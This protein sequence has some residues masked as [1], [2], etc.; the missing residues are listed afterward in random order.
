M[1]HSAFYEGS[2]LRAS[3]WLA[4][5][6]SVLSNPGE[7]LLMFISRP[8]QLC[9]CVNTRGS[10]FLR[11][12]C[13]FRNSS[14]LLLFTPEPLLYVLRERKGKRERER[15]KLVY[16]NNPHHL[17]LE[18]VEPSLILSDSWME[19]QMEVCRVKGLAHIDQSYRGV[20]LAE[21]NWGLLL[22]TSAH[23]QGCTALVL[24]LTHYTMTVLLQSTFTASP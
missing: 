22:M 10:Y 6:L 4:D 23:C 9:V 24:T 19:G 7:S 14:V 13:S 2:L 11:C 12:S 16:L 17:K 18:S 15:E 8:N 5:M 21:G 1:K 20:N 3:K